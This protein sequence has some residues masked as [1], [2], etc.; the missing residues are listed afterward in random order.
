LGDQKKM[1][2]RRTFAQSGHTGCFGGSSR[3]ARWHIFK[4]NIPI[5]ANFGGS[6]SGKCWYILWAF[7]LFYGHLIDFWTFG[8]FSGYLVYF[9][10]FWYVVQKKIW[11]PWEAPTIRDHADL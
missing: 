5:W 4:P 9:F 6:Y 3:V 10:P 7:G 11:Q 2:K 8:I 1:P